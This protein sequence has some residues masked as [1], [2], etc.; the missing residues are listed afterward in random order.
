MLSAAFA[1]RFWTE[2]CRPIGGA[3]A[4]LLAAAADAITA[5]I[6]ADMSVEPARILISYMVDV[7]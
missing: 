2:Y 7:D 5:A 3:A 6:A 1:G 4:A